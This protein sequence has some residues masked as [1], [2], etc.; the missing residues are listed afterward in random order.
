MNGRQ[1]IQCIELVCAWPG[2]LNSPG[3]VSGA[4]AEEREELKGL[5]QY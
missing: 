1:C 2:D 5:V 4:G 3:D